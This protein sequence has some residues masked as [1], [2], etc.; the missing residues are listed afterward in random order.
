MMGCDTL[1]MVG[2]SFPYIEFYPK[3]G[4]ARAV[5]IDLDPVRI[6]LRYPVEVGLVGDSRNTLQALLPMLNRNEDRG[7]LEK[8]QSGMKEWN[9]LMATRGSDDS[10]PMKPQVVAHELGKRIPANAIVACDSGTNT[11]WW[12]RHIPAKRGQMHSVFREPGEHGLRVAVCGGRADR[13]S[14]PARVRIRRRW[15]LHHADG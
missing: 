10:M 3:P 12:A 11:S 6:G 13:V 8:A 15:R 1:L 7:F 9:E 2:T 5:Q 14:R 4:K